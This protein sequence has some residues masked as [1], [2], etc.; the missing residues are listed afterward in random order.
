MD[1]AEQ[2]RAAHDLRR[3]ARPR[4]GRAEHHRDQVGRRQR[5]AGGQ[6]H[7]EQ[8]LQLREVAEG[9]GL[10]VA[11]G[12]QGTEPRHGDAAGGVRHHHHRR[13]QHPEG[14]MADRQHG[15]GRD[16]AERQQEQPVAPH[17]HH[18]RRH[19]GQ[20]DRPQLRQRRA[21]DR[22]AQRQAAGQ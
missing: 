20:R 15:F 1:E 5:D 2:R 12:L 11:V 13:I 7:A 9:L 14:E 17:H 6:R 19:L 21:R 10:R 8:R 16:Q 4:P 3:L 22:W 18:D